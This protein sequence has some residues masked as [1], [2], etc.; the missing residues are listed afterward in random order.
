MPTGLD[1]RVVHPTSG[2]GVAQDCSLAAIRPDAT[3]TASTGDAGATPAARGGLANRAHRCFHAG[4]PDR[5]WLTDLIELAIRILAFT[6]RAEASGLVPSV[7]RVVY[8][9]DDSMIEAF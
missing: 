9:Q 5:L 7:G 3:R 4:V 2:I 6:D 8:C 1:R